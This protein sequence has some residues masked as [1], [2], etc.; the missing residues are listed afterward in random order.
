MSDESSFPENRSRAGKLSPSSFMRKLRPEYYSDTEDRA[1]YVLD[2]PVLEYHLDTITQRNQ[3]HEF[4]IFCRKLCERT[5]CPNLRPQTGPEGGGDSKADTESYPVTEEVAALTY[6]G[7]LRDGNERWA[8]AFSAKKTWAQ[9][10]RSDVEG[11]V[12]AGRGY[13]RIICVTSRF[14]KAKDRASLEDELSKQHGIPIRIRGSSPRSS[15]RTVRISHS[16]I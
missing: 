10:V 7:Q 5:I 2:K 1:F 9:K 14:A 3:T 4:E 11:L 6:V 16:T 13:N 12:Q 8:F 15:K